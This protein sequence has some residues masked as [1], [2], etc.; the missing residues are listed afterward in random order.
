MVCVN[1]DQARKDAQDREAIVEALRTA[2]SHGDKAL[3]G[4]KGY[5]KFVKAGG[6]RFTVNE[7]KI[8]EEARYDGKWVLTT[9]GYRAAAE[10][11]LQYKR[12][13]M[14]EDMFRTMKSLLET[15]PI[16]HKCDET[17]RGHVFCSFLALLLRRALEQRL[18]DGA[19]CAPFRLSLLYIP[20]S[21]PAPG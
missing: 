21:R 6:Q 5:R 3:I 13:W 4:N 10:V 12:L 9:N 20:G 1:D 8:R 14:V 16:F 18:E 19:S 17:I 7:K 2:L 15:R 11:A